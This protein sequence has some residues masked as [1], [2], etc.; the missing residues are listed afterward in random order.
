MKDFAFETIAD[1]LRKIRTEKNYSQDY[2]AKKIGITQKAYSKIE[3]NETRLNVDVL[4]KISDILEVPI[5]V[6]FKGVSAPI[7]NDFSHRSGGDNVIYKN[8]S[9][10]KYEKLYEKILQS[11]DEIIQAKN[12]EI[13]TLK[14]VISKIKDLK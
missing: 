5:E 13:T 3:N 14:F 7:L 11:K 4:Q 1:R 9:A 6:F 12:E 2:L 10:D 8:G